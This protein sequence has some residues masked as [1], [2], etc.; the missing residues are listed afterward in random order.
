MIQHATYRGLM[1]QHAT[2]RGLMIQHATYRGLMIQHATYRGLMIQHA[3]YRGLMIQHATY[4]GLMIQHATYRGVTTLRWL[5]SLCA[6]LFR[7]PVRPRTPLSGLTWCCCESTEWVF[8]RPPEVV[9]SSMIT[10]C[11]LASLWKGGREEKGW[12]DGREEKGWR[13]GREEKGWKGGREEKGWRVE[14]RRR[15]GGV[16]ERSRDGGVEE[17]RMKDKREPDEVFEG[18]LFVN[19]AS[20]TAALCNC[21]KVRS[22]LAVVVIDAGVVEAVCCPDAEQFERGFVG[23]AF[24]RVAVS[25]DTG[26]LRSARRLLLRVHEAPHKALPQLRSLKVAQSGKTDHLWVVSVWWW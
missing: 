17:R 6:L 9:T 11:L 7:L 1:I 19:H 26:G 8:I 10:R 3:T 14:E 12:R 4:R 15:D 5:L 24:C 22:A 2:Y 13:G 25:E 16:E 23:V 18:G 21:C 20:C